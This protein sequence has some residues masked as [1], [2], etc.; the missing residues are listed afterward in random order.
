MTR[1][2]TEANYS[3]NLMS[4]AMGDLPMQMGPFGPVMMLIFEALI[5]IPFW[6]IFKKAGYSGWLALL[7]LV[8]RTPPFEHSAA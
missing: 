2:T 8:P 6:S 1:R 5:V 7:M 3:E 4:G